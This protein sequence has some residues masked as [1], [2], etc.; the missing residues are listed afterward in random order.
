MLPKFSQPKTEGLLYVNTNIYSGTVDITSNMSDIYH[1][2]TKI[3]I[4]QDTLLRLKDNYTGS[5]TVSKNK[6]YQHISK[7]C[8]IKLN[9]MKTKVP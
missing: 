4:Y 8:S 9:S 3:L 6:I 2:V 7:I 1:N 5:R